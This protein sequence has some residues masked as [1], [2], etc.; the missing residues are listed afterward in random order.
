MGNDMTISAFVYSRQPLLQQAQSMSST[1]SASITETARASAKQPKEGILGSLLQFLSGTFSLFRLSKKTSTLLGVSTFTAVL[2][3]LLG[4]VADAYALEL[5]VAIEEDV[6]T[7]QVG[8]S[9]KSLLRD[10]SG[11]VVAEIPAMGSVRAE[12]QGNQ[13]KIHQ[14]QGNQFWL[15]PTN[16]GF[17]A[18]GNKWYRGRTHVI[19]VDGALTAVNYVDLE[20]YLY[21]VVGSE[22]P[23]SWPLEA[24][25]AQAV[26]ARTYV[27][28][29]RQN[30]GNAIYDVG[31][32]T[33]WQVY[34][35][36]EKE[37]SSTHTAVKATAGQVLTYN[38]RII[39]SVFHSSSGGHTENV[40]HV[41]SSP[42]PYLRGVADFDQYAPVF[43]WREQFSA[44]DLRNRITGVGRILSITP[45]ELT[46]TGRVASVRV[47][48]DQNTRVLTGTELRRSLGLRSTLFTIRPEIGR[49]A[50]ASSPASI[51]SAFLIDGR[52][53]GHGVGMSQ[54]GAY[55]MAARGY[56]YQQIVGHYFRNT[57]LSV[58]QPR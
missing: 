15:E 13:V 47:V 2:S 37:A 8:S 42:R 40:E 50:S 31:D 57:Q 49:V 55:G 51:P 54:W 22:M 44:D 12:S 38:G 41:W 10:S 46:P 1:D 17:V 11:R 18:I 32:T 24:L 25:K 27:L 56:N 7:V 29:R 34:S 4:M 35:G 19:A 26:A 39:E 20:E 30:N 36:L 52:G 21:S 3:C 48:G 58:I 45:I 16:G 43:Q 14:F 53:F 28:Y 6:R 23:T 9:T 33:T 5:R